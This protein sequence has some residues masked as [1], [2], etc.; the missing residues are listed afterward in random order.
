M[1]DWNTEA[2]RLSKSS[3]DSPGFWLTPAQITT[4]SAS[5]QSSYP[6]A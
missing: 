4:T 3:R 6:P 5:E 2:L 1:M